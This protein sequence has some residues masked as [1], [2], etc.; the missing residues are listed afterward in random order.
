MIIICVVKSVGPPGAPR[1]LIRKSIEPMYEHYDTMVEPLQ[2]PLECLTLHMYHD[3]SELENKFVVSV[4]CCA[5]RVVVR[6]MH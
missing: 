2:A 3:R 1:W 5:Q 4:C 6:Y